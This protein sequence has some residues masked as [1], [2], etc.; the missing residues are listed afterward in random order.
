MIKAAEIFNFLFAGF[1]RGKIVEQV[2]L[3]DDRNGRPALLQGLHHRQLGVGEL[4]C[5]LKQ[6]HRHIDIF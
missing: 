2:H 1:Q 6:H 3:V 5:R 4:P